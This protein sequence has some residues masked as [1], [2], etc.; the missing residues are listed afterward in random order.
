LARVVLAVDSMTLPRQVLPG[1]FYMLTRRCTQR[2][3]LLRPDPELN[4]AFLYC[5]IEAALRF[6]IGL[7]HSAVESNHHHTEFL[8]RIGMLCEFMEHLHK[9]TAKCVNSMRGRWENCWA[10]EPACVV[11]LVERDDVINKIGYAATNPVKDGLVETATDWPGINTIEA[12]LEGTELRATRP[13]FFREEGDM[14]A[15]VSIKLEVPPQLGDRERF[16]NDV[17]AR[18][19]KLETRFL[20]IRSVLGRRVLGRKAIL[21]QSWRDSP[22]SREPRRVLRPR[23]AARSKW[24]RVEALQ[25]NRSFLFEYQHAR[26]AWLAGHPIPFP[27]GTYWLARFAGVP[28][29]SATLN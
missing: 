10:S 6:D 26:K 13:D 12:L 11:E 14:P 29:A 3:F 18:I 25:R 22:D 4:N 23:V 19:T 8:D 17:R 5:L 24:A 21:R 28:V 27:P 2:Q 7:L 1:R 15:E 20:I 16:R 9:M